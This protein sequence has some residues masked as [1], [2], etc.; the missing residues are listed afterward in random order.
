MKLI[1]A[2]SR[3]FDFLDTSFID[4][5]FWMFDLSPASIISGGAAGIDKLAEQYATHN[6]IQI[7]VKNAEWDTFGKSAGPIRNIYMSAAGDELL[8]IWDGESRGSADIRR[9]MLD[10]KKPVHEIIIKSKVTEKKK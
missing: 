1:I 7:E 6:N 9:K 2:G 5:C 8:L 10:A 4:H 3:H